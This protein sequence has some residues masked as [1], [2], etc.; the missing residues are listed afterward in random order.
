[1]LAGKTCREAIG[2]L[3]CRFLLI[4]LRLETSGTVSCFIAERSPMNYSISSVPT[5]LIIPQLPPIGC[6]P[7]VNN[8]SHS[9]LGVSQDVSVVTDTLRL[10][11]VGHP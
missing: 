11:P 1:M 5:V 2:N 4:S 9:S 6:V 8:T 10:L 7:F 3:V